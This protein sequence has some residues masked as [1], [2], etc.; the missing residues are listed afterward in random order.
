M[1]G[2]I[3]QHKQLAFKCFRIGNMIRAGD[4]YLLNLGFYT[5]CSKTYTIRIY[6]YTAVSKHFQSKL[7]GSPIKAFAAFLA[8]TYFFRKKD[9]PYT[10]LTI[11]GQM[12]TQF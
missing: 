11:R 12:N 6:R 5:Q 9:N 10:I 3:T 8:Q 2:I 1:C 4:K 7:F